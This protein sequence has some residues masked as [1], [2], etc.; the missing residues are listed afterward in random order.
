MKNVRDLI[1]I[2]LLISLEV[3]FTRFLSFQIDII[4]IGFGFLPI[5]ICAIYFGPLYT[6]MASLVADLLGMMIFP[7]A[8]YFVG[9]SISAFLSGAIYG[10]FLYKKEKSWFRITLCVLC[11]SIFVDLILNTYW[12]S[13]ITGKAAN[14]LIFPRLL[15]TAVMFPVQ[16]LL[17]YETSRQFAMHFKWISNKTV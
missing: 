8:G 7:K 17:I 14:I 13:I 9:F 3:I 16:I 1:F 10:L 6:A 11:I 15:K 5:A 2:A 12:L 4:R